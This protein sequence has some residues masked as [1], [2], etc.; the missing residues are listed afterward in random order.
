MVNSALLLPLGSLF[1]LPKT[2]GTLCI[3][4]CYALLWSSIPKH[5]SNSS[6][7]SHFLWVSL[8]EITS[9]LLLSNGVPS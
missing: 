2:Q 9:L 1:Y 5:R 3:E 4:G 8:S 6:F 7:F